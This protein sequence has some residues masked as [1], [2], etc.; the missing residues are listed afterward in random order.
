MCRV[1]KKTFAAESE[2]VE[3]NDELIKGGSDECFDST[4]EW[5]RLTKEL[6]Q[7][8]PQDLKIKW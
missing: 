5:T 8:S 7:I 3:C 4:S 2:V 6:S 1:L